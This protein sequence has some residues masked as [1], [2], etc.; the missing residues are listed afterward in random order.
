MILNFKIDN[1][2]KIF[3]PRHFSNQNYYFELAHMWARRAL[4]EYYIR[5]KD[6]ATGTFSHRRSRLSSFLGNAYS[7]YK[8]PSF[9]G[10]K[11][12]LRDQKDASAIK[13]LDSE[14]KYIIDAIIFAIDSAIKNPIRNA[15]RTAFFAEKAY[16]VFVATRREKRVPLVLE[17]RRYSF[18]TESE[19]QLWDVR[20]SEISSAF[21]H[22]GIR[23]IK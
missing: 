11:N 22:N 15:R 9:E 10:R 5:S 23:R 17:Y 8:N 6:V 12:C 18:K 13:C 16:E 1:S 3:C 19:L 7:Y 4:N 2:E 21:L 20:N 14:N